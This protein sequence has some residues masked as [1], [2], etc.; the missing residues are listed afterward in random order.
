MSQIHSL[1]DFITVNENFKS[2]VNL[3]LHLNKSDKIRN[4]IPTKTTA[5]LM[6]NYINSALYGNE[7]ATLLVG[8]YG[9]GK[10][11]FLLTL[12]F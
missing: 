12:Q 9:K 5:E 10:S 1:S 6:K 4:Y 8:S 3:F 7:R 2:S 11:Y